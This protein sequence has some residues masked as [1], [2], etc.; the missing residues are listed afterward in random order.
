MRKIKVLIVDDSPLI[1][2][3]LCEILGSDPEIEVV[4]TA[5]DPYIARDK[6]LKVNP[7]VITLDVEMP[8]MDG[9]SFLKRLM[10]YRPLPVVMISSYTQ[11]NCALTIEA[12]SI[13]AVDFVTKPASGDIT[14]GMSKLSQEIIQKTKSAARVKL[15]AVL[16]KQPAKTVTLSPLSLHNDQLI[17][18]GASTGGSY[19]IQYIL[20]RMPADTPGITIALHMPERYTK[21]FA[22]R[23]NQMCSMEVKEA[24]EGDF[25]KKGLALIARG[26]KHM[27]IKRRVNGL[28]TTL[29]D[30]PPVGNLKPSI[31]MLFKSAAECAGSK[32]IGV[33]LTGMGMDGAKGMLEMKEAGAYTIAQDENTSLIYGMPRAAVQ[34]EAAQEVVPLQ[35][36]PERILARLLSAAK[37]IG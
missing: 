8:R 17:V 34:M 23:M 3:I 31:D 24:K 26:G 12:L 35:Q 2:K 14:K 11:K 27:M 15:E 29:Y 16:L 4:G 7:D 10:R 5:S 32:A 21:I 13:G 19:A 25:L 28:Y 22:E 30:G 37:E 36:I 6:V 20:S 18:I 9:I 1:R 33:I